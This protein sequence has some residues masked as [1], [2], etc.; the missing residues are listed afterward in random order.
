MVFLSKIFVI[1]A[2][3]EPETGESRSFVNPDL[4]DILQINFGGV[5]FLVAPFG[6]FKALIFGGVGEGEAET[7]KEARI[8]VL[9]V[10]DLRELEGQDLLDA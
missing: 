3:V 7:G 10:F 1:V 9:A 5:S 2:T 8:R 6:S 4:V